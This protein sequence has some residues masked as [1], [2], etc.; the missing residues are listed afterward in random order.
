MKIISILWGCR[1][2]LG[3]WW[4][5]TQLEHESCGQITVVPWQTVP[6]LLGV[7]LRRLKHLAPQPAA[8][9]STPQGVL[10]ATSASTTANGHDATH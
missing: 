7:R 3:A 4:V 10:A 6:A 5:L 2:S 9:A 1:S 8:T